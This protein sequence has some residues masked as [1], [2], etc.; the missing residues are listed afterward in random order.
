MQRRHRRHVRIEQLGDSKESDRR[1]VALV[2]TVP[3]L[4]LLLPAVAVVIANGGGT[5]APVR[6]S[7][8]VERFLLFYSGVFALVA[9]TATVG[10]G[11]LATDGILRTPEWRIRAQALHRMLSLVALAALANHVMLEV[12]AHR[13]SLIDGFVPFLATRRTF[14][15]GLGTLASDLFIVIIITGIMRARFAGARRWLWRT[16]HALAYAAWPLAIVHGLLAGRSAKPYVDWSYGGCLALVGLALTL[17]IVMRSRSGGVP[18]GLTDRAFS[19]L[20]PQAPLAH[21]LVHLTASRVRTTRQPALPPGQS[22]HSPLPGR[23]ARPAWPLPEYDAE[24][25]PAPRPNGR[26]R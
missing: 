10:A 7:A 21:D 17:R 8:D 20:P 1:R 11:L 25:S 23:Q 6:I 4:S 12:L 9:L 26:E 24:W 22:A 15:M 13:V 16:L 5:S 2:V 14:F 3:V 19:P 18:A